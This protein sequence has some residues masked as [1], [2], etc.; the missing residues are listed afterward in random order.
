MG[1][2][3]DNN[4]A[5]LAGVRARYGM[6]VFLVTAHDDAVIW[7]ARRGIVAERI[8]HLDAA[9]IT[10]GD[11]AIGNLPFHLAAEVCARGGR[12]FTIVMDVPAAVRA[13]G[14]SRNYTADQM[15]S[16]GARLVEYRIIE[17]GP[18]NP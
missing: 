16:F 13:Q 1:S 12:F 11:I 15:E 9:R 17:V 18:A 6:A 10:P 14:H 2:G 4:S 5:T 8:T 3:I 7:A